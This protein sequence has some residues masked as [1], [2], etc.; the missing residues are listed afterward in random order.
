MQTH[1]FKA[2]IRTESGKGP[3]RRARSAGKVPAV[4]YGPRMKP[5]TLLLDAKSLHDF[6]EHHNYR[7][8]LYTLAVDG[9]S[10]FAGKTFKVADLQRHYLDK[11]VMS[12]DFAEVEMDQ[13]VVVEVPVFFDGT[14][15]GV[16]AGGLM[17]RLARSIKVRCLPRDI[18]KSIH[19]DVS[20]LNTG[21]TLYLENF[22]L[23]ETLEAVSVPRTPII[24]CTIP[25]TMRGKGAAADEEVAAEG[26]EE[27]AEGGEESAES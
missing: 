11:D 6:I 24:A 14:P 9:S 21:T 17:Q 13:Q 23:P 7:T 26:G 1:E 25:R 12:V 8:N 3:A 22:T 4:A 16:K 5:V 10:E 20:G 15:A 2:E 18:P 27:A 19:W